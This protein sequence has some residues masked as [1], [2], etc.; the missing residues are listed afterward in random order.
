MSYSA[1]AALIVFHRWWSDRREKRAIRP[2]THGLLLGM[3]FKAASHIGAIAVTSLVAGTAS[4][5]FAV[6]H[7]N[8]AAPLGIIG[9]A[10]AL[11]VVSVAVMPFAVLALLFM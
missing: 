3:P 5:I 2:K 4:S 11:P 6:Y 8:N 7:F 9:N 10:L 1:T